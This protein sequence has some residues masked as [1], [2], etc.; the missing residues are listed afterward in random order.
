MKI[1]K[2]VRMSDKCEMD[3]QALSVRDRKKGDSEISK[4]I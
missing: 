4:T 2:L 1:D 3:N